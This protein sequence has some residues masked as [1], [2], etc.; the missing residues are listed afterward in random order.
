MR[1]DG[2]NSPANQSGYPSGSHA[3]GSH[4]PG[5]V[6]RIRR[7][8][9]YV[10]IVASLLF[11]LILLLYADLLPSLPGAA[12]AAL[13]ALAAVARARRWCAQEQRDRVRDP[14]SAAEGSCVDGTRSSD[15][16]GGFSGSRS[17]RPLGPGVG[18]GVG[19][20]EA[21]SGIDPEDGFGIGG[22]SHPDPSRIRIRRALAA[23][24]LLV[25]CGIGMVALVGA[26]PPPARHAVLT[27]SALGAL[28]TSYHIWKAPR[29]AGEGAATSGSGGFRQAATSGS[30]AEASGAAV[31]GRRR[32]L[33]V[34]SSLRR[35]L[36]GTDSSS[37]S[38]SSSGPSGSGPGGSGPGSEVPFRGRACSASRDIDAD[39]AADPGADPDPGV[40][41]AR[42]PIPSG[43]EEDLVVEGL[44]VDWGIVGD[45][46]DANRDTN[47][48][49]NADA[50]AAAVHA[51]AAAN[52]EAAASDTIRIR[53]VS[54]GI[55]MRRDRPQDGIQP[56]PSS[57]GARARANI[58]G[59][60]SPGSWIPSLGADPLP[61]V[62]EKIP[63]AACLRSGADEPIKLE[64]AP[65]FSS[66]DPNPDPRSSS[67]LGSKA[68]PSGGMGDRIGERRGGGGGWDTNGGSTSVFPP[69][70]TSALCELHAT[71]DARSHPTRS[72]PFGSHG[73]GS[74]VAGSRP[75][76]ADLIAIFR[77]LL[78]DADERWLAAGRRGLDLPNMGEAERGRLQ[79]ALPPLVLEEAHTHFREQRGRGA[80][81]DVEALVLLRERLH[82]IRS[83][84][85]Q[86]AI[87][88]RW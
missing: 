76:D 71:M 61:M 64:L 16:T 48:D 31:A 55:P 44:D 29:Q 87:G 85:M 78:H 73:R 63:M 52:A 80:V 28:V 11:Q 69:E 88:S 13:A 8:P 18:S 5:S 49:A 84:P 45:G 75:K 72:D 50:D 30:G 81:S 42:G 23:A 36:V 38:D 79:G 82:A 70:L 39:C 53:R 7:I 20:G 74:G 9:P 34:S 4:A 62:S 32:R 57:T 25:L 35:L 65:R 22:G 47:R 54:A 58:S 77:S 27:I 68:S 41:G 83:L 14:G 56:D 40:D 10:G 46:D 19:S 67:W 12:A 17:P 21:G 15:D 59:A 2:M 24:D 1:L 37:V 51:A 3:P 86:V 43:R 33:Q 26:A 66:S 6:R 60:S